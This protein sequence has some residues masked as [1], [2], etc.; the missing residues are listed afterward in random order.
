MYRNIYPTFSKGKFQSKKFYTS[1][2]RKN[3]NV[4]FSNWNGFLNDR[5]KYSVFSKN[6]KW[7]KKFFS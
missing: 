6:K 4:K 2:F 1:I 3:Q 7:N 5:I